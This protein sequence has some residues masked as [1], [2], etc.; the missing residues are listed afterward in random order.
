MNTF[1]PQDGWTVTVEDGKEHYRREHGLA[2]VL[3]VWDPAGR[4]GTVCVRSTY[5]GFTRTHADTA[6]DDPAAFWTAA[7]LAADTLAAPIPIAETMDGRPRAT[8]EGTPL[9]ADLTFTTTTGRPIVL[10]VTDEQA[11]TLSSEFHSLEEHVWSADRTDEPESRAAVEDE[12]PPGEPS[13]AHALLAVLESR[14]GLPAHELVVQGDWQVFLIL[15]ADRIRPL[16]A[17]EDELVAAM[18]RYWHHEYSSLVEQP[19]LVIRRPQG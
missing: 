4:S 13:T 12:A 7:N 1:A 11:D 5:A 8:P 17:R 2:D 16:M 3:A 14:F 18:G 19:C 15:G 10:T 9:A 6:V